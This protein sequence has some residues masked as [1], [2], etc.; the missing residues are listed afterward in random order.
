[1]TYQT[2]PEALVNCRRHFAGLVNTFLAPRPRITLSAWADKYR[3]LSPESSAHPTQWETANVPYLREIMDAVGDP[4]IPFMVVMKSSQ[5]GFT[6]GVLN[7]AVGY[8]IDQDPSPI[9]LVQPSDGDAEKWSKMKL[10]PM[11][12]D[13]PVLKGKVADA[14]SRSSENTILLKQFPGGILNI[15]GATS[16][17]GLAAMP[18]RVALLDEVDRY[19]ASAGGE[20]DPVKLVERRLMT[21]WNRKQVVG[22]TPTLKH[23]SRIEKAFLLSDQRYYHVPCPHCGTFQV[24][25]MGGKDAPYGLKWQDDDPSTVAYLCGVVNDHGEQVGG[26]GALIEESQK[27]RMVRHGRWEATNP[28]GRYPG[29]HINALISLFDVARWS[30]IVTEFLESRHDRDQLQ[31]FVNTVLGETWEERG[32]SLSATGLHARIEDYGA[33][34]PET[35]RVLTAG[36]DVQKDRLEVM[37]KG[38]G[39]GEESWLVGHYRLHGDPEVEEVWQRLE[40]L[41]TRPWSTAS[42]TDHRVRVCMID[43]GYLASRVYWF[44]R[45]R[46]SRNVFASQG[47]DD[48]MKGPPLSRPTRANRD[49]V[50]VFSINTIAMKDS[51]FRRLKIERPGPKYLH[52]C[53]P[54]DSGGDAEFFAQYEAEKLVIE[55]VK[56]RPVRKYK[57]VRERNEA[58][59]LEVLNMAALHALGQTARQALDVP[60]VVQD[61]EPTPE[62]PVDELGRPLEPTTPVRG[63]RRGPRRGGNWVGGWR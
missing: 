44:V 1:M 26:C 13:T 41:L 56:G 60:R 38:W 48:R 31:V 35:V 46:Q 8:Y 9:M 18:A 53:G 50:K 62:T 19:P 30:A 15:V 39:P 29:W 49:G 52:F 57:Q 17:K 5:V 40:G 2:S 4:D 32:E 23:L 21:F 58:I 55:K 47:S 12:R 36:V 37:V 22:S 33:P 28:N 34:V 6:E 59:D 10:A 25:K 61:T 45:P 16:P 11:L 54:T 3:V 42:G 27:A 51:L 7:N 14:K 43:A 63:L 20:G 24:L